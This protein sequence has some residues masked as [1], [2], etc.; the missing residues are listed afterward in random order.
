MKIKL[1]TVMQMMVNMAISDELTMN[2]NDL[3]FSD[4]NSP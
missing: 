3:P 2:V 4:W 1:V